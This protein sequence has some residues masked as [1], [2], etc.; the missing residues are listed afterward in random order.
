MKEFSGGAPIVFTGDH[1]CHEAD[2]AARAVA[3][4]LRNAMRC[5]ETPVEGP[6]LSS[7]GWKYYPN[8]ISAK[9]AMKIPPEELNEDELTDRHRIDYI[10]VSPGVRVKRY[11]THP[12]LRKDV[13][14]Y[15]SDHF[16][17]TAEIEL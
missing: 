8:P 9:A 1:N 7:P 2:P 16:P 11:A 3:K 10:Y 15:P 14:M 5:C 13:K 6:W 17:V 4:V 12:D